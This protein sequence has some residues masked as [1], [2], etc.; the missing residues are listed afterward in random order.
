VFEDNGFLLSRPL[1]GKGG[2]AFKFFLVDHML[3]EMA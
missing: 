1:I 2:E 3:G